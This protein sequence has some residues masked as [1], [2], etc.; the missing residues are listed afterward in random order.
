M[1]ELG[2]IAAAFASAACLLLPSRRLALVPVRLGTG[3]RVRGLSYGAF[4]LLA[5]LSWRFFSVK[6]T[7]E[8]LPSFVSAWLASL[9]ALVLMSGLPMA[10]RRAIIG[11]VSG[12]VWV[13][14][15]T[16]GLHAP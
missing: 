3:P 13:A 16:G 2:G 10:W 9:A 6:A 1:S 12:C 7:H 4:V 8:A 5:W 14:L 15:A 11:V